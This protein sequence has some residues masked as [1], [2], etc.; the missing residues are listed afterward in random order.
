ME[1]LVFNNENSNGP[2]AVD[3]QVS[4]HIS[5]HVDSMLHACTMS[6]LEVSPGLALDWLHCWLNTAVVVGAL[7]ETDIS[8][9]EGANF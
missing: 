1:T 3:N 5:M 2:V 9:F 6:E 7:S 4:L 8:H